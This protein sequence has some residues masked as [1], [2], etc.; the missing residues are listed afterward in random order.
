M[1]INNTIVSIIKQVIANLKTKL[2]KAI[3]IGIT[4]KSYLTSPFK[5]SSHSKVPL[6]SIENQKRVL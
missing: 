5:F 3:Q 1:D 2:E 6:S 4:Y